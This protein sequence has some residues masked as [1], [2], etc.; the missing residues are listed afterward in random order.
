MGREGPEAGESWRLVSVYTLQST[1]APGCARP[2][3]H[4][5]GDGGGGGLVSA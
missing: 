2:G 5:D 1:R 3:V 4:G